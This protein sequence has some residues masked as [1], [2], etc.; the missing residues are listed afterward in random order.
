L[1]TYARHASAA[2]FYVHKTKNITITK[3]KPYE[4]ITI[5]PL[6]PRLKKSNGK[7]NGVI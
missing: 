7:D 3:K 4:E 2:F 1:P 6:K 5:M